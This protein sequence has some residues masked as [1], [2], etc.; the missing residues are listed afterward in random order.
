MISMMAARTSVGVKEVACEISAT[1][2][3]VSMVFS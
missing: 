2:S 3:F 1:K